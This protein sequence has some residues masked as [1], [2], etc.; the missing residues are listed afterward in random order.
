MRTIAFGL[1]KGGVGKTSIAGNVAALA[2]RRGKVLLIDGDPQ[3]SASSWLLTAP[4]K[5]ELADVL[6]GK[7]TLGEAV[8]PGGLT[9]N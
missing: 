1:Q 2:S 8:V 7:A 3:G 9:G 4:A 5:W 6:Q